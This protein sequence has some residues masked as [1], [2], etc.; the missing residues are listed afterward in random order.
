M[1]TDPRLIELARLSAGL[2]QGAL[3]KAIGKTQPFISQIER[4]E[5]EIPSDLL[6][7]WATAC[8]VPTSFFG[9]SEGPLSPAVSGMIHRRMVTLPTK[10]FV[11]AQAKV[12]MASLEVDSLFG[13]VDVI[14]A[15][16][17]PDLPKRTGPEDAARVVRREWRVPQGP[18]PDL[19]ALVE[20]AGIPVL[21][22]S[23]FHEKHS[24][25][26]HRGRWFDWLIAINSEHA[27]SRQRFSIAHE[28]AHIVLR[29]NAYAAVDDDEAKLL[30]D[31]ANSFA[32]ELLLPREDARRELRS[33]DFRRLVAL[34]E[35][36]R[37]SI[38][39]LIRRA[40]DLQLID[41]KQKQ[42]FY[43]QLSQQPGGRRREP[44]EFESE[45]PTLA[46]Q[47]ISSLE[48]EGMSIPDI[49]D[50]MRAH[51]MVVRQRYLGE[52]ALRTVGDRPARARL[53]LHRPDPSSP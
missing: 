26:S 37:V 20:S 8:D 32:S 21:M 2:T 36:W 24:A 28:L 9:R 30:E 52:R 43:I 5:R 16:Q 45:T 47:M 12:D 25:T 51:E 3:A 44:A 7:A 35:R 4:G 42:W 50:L 33:L 13:E 41:P 38:A 27:A 14:P 49:A 18:L 17:I 40:G 48:S 39:F 31:Q 46:R 11:L 22:L 23:D 15:L 1:R 19:V 34:K 53:Q 6:D 10:P 29:H